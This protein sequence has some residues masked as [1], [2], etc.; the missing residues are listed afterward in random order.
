MVAA[1]RKGIAA[2]SPAPGRADDTGKAHV[3]AMEHA[4][5][6]KRYWKKRA[7]QDQC[8]IDVDSAQVVQNLTIAVDGSAGKT[9]D[10]DDTAGWG[11]VV[12]RPDTQT[13]S[14]EL[15]L[16]EYFGPVITDPGVSGYFGVASLTNNTAE[17]S[18]LA[19]TFRW[20]LSNA[21]DAQVVDILF[22]STWAANITR[23][24]WK[25]KSNKD[26]AVAVQRLLERV[27]EAGFV[28]NW[29]HVKAHLG[30]FM[31]EAADA[32]AKRGA[33]GQ[34]GTGR[35]PNDVVQL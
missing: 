33:E 6:S 27:A 24:L 25:A 23:R 12:A 9:R 11:S 8:K 28:I 32:A 29:H 14:S 15:E 21:V 13:R 35:R 16:A 4:P 2:P 34:T 20:L 5:L 18:A 17:I 3:A 7:W 1:C 31:N 10:G 22:D 19:A 26:A 30:H